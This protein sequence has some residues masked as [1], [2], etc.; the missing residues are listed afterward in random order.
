[1]TYSSMAEQMSRQRDAQRRA[2]RPDRRDVLAAALRNTPLFAYATERHLRAITKQAKTV[3]VTKE[4]TIM[5]EGERGNTFY[6]VL[7]G[8]VRVSRNGRKVAELGPGKSFGEL[9]LLSDAPRNAT[10]VSVGDAELV[11]FDRKPFGKLLDE[12]PEFA[13]H[14]LEAVAARLRACDARAVN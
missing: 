1:V 7:D 14:L 9:A 12:S 4:T 6:V 8:T 5:T 10:V 3:V 2:R 11:S 13:R